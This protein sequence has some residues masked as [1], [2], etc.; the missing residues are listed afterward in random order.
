[1]TTLTRSQILET[2]RIFDE[3]DGR[4]IEWFC[5]ETWSMKDL[6]K[7]LRD[8][9]E[10]HDLSKESGDYDCQT[11][12]EWEFQVT[13]IQYVIDARKSYKTWTEADLDYVEGLSDKNPRA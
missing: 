9:K 6:R 11:T 13:A 5:S 1:M 12:D 8:S 10:S 7:E 3:D 4:V 2:L